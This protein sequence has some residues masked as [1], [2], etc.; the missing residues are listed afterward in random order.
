MGARVWDQEQLHT[1]PRDQ[2]TRTPDFVSNATLMKILHVVVFPG[3]FNRETRHFRREC[4]DSDH[5]SSFAQWRLT[6]KE[7]V[8][9]GIY[10]MHPVRIEPAPPECRAFGAL[11]QKLH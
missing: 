6:V 5:G 4:T 10:Q 2:A 9:G 8:L 3:D 11:S 7:A 1:A